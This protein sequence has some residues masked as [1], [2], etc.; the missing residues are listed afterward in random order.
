MSMQLSYFQQRISQQRILN[1]WNLSDHT[2]NFVLTEW[3]LKKKQ[4]VLYIETGENE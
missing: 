2:C 1:P 3:H 4:H